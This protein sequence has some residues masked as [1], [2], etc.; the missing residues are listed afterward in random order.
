MILNAIKKDLLSLDGAEVKIF[1]QKTTLS[2]RSENDITVSAVDFINELKDFEIAPRVATRLMHAESSEY[3]SDDY[4]ADNSYNWSSLI[5]HDFDYK[6]YETVLKSVDYGDNVVYSGDV[7]IEIKFHR[8]GDI[9]GNY[10][11]TAFLLFDDD[12]GFLE[13]MQEINTFFDV[14]V[15]ELDFCCNTSIIGEGVNCWNKD[16]DLDFEVYGC[17]LDDVKTEISNH[18]K[19]VA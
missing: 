14:K 10:T 4:N 5:D 3:L 2:S 8:F 19:E 1:G 15:N 16:K 18:L 13:V 17:D 9:R 12:Y 7:L 6:V 11:D